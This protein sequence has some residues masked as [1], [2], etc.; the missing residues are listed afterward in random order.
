MT[1]GE[2]LVAYI[3]DHGSDI[4]INS[5][6][7]T[8]SPSQPLGEMSSSSDDEIVVLQKK[9]MITNPNQPVVNAVALQDPL[10]LEV[11]NSI[12]SVDNKLKILLEKSIGPSDLAVG[13][14]ENSMSIEQLR[15][16]V[17]DFIENSGKIL[18][19]G[20]NSNMIIKD[21]QSIASK[22]NDQSRVC[23]GLVAAINDNANSLGEIK[24]ILEDL[25]KIL[26]VKP[27]DSLDLMMREISNRLCLFG[28]GLKDISL[29][30][31]NFS[32]M[33]NKLDRLSDGPRELAQFCDLAYSLHS[34]FREVGD[35][36]GS[37]LAQN[38]SLL[39]PYISSIGDSCC[40]TVSSVIS[41][42]VG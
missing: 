38:N 17:S 13:F 15:T 23:F 14:R 35:T 41:S 8:D 34:A 9:D 3:E 37:A 33:S 31:G 36:M 12:R 42:S 16:N 29:L 22:V 19:D 4:V 21:V 5:G 10:A 40:E 20:I 2:G 24:D 18:K 26:S 27:D 39:I 32:I 25:G 28:N 1:H 6:D 7:E 30:A 11:L